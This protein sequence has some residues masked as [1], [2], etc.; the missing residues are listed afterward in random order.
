MQER[1]N[2]LALEKQWALEEA[3]RQMLE[4][5]KAEELKS[6]Q[7][8]LLNWQ[9]NAAKAGAESNKLSD[10]GHSLNSK[11][12]V[13]FDGRMDDGGVMDAESAD[14][15]SDN[16]DR[17][18]PANKGRAAL[19]EIEEVH[20][21]S[22]G[23]PEIRASEKRRT[24]PQA[25]AS[26]LVEESAIPAVVKEASNQG[27]R[28]GGPIPT[29]VKQAANPGFGNLLT[30]VTEEAGDESPLVARSSRRLQPPTSEKQAP[31]Q[32][33]GSEG[34]KENEQQ[35]EASDSAYLKGEESV[36]GVNIAEAIPAAVLPP[37]R[38]RMVVP[39][40]FTAKE[41]RPNVPARES[42]LQEIELKKVRVY[43]PL[44]YILVVKEI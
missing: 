35:L 3:K 18:I 23:R 44:R 17:Y 38:R 33:P 42:R 12:G 6:A 13:R 7:E 36:Q 41:L 15:L 26:G 5:R 2:K 30:G 32:K 24:S 1:T 14:A 22:D 8:D 20:I 19:E 21:E 11:N 29:V 16:E 43:N 28:E 31:V 25:S 4:K 37:P 27:L 34:D 39:V 10:D 40:Q 9:K